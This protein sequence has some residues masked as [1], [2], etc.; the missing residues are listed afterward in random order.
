MTPREKTLGKNTR[1]KTETLP[2]RNPKKDKLSHHR[3]KFPSPRQRKEHNTRRKIEKKERKQSTWE[4]R[5]EEKKLRAK[6]VPE[7][8]PSDAREGNSQ[9]GRWKKKNCFGE[10]SS[11]WRLKNKKNGKGKALRQ[12]LL[13]TDASAKHRWPAPPRVGSPPPTTQSANV[14]CTQPVQRNDLRFQ[15]APGAPFS[16]NNFPSRTVIGWKYGSIRYEVTFCIQCPFFFRCSESLLEIDH[17]P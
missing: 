2:P 6:E 14:A 5:S 13:V 10:Q 12:S 1:S 11:L 7:M 3:Q 8:L 17:K 15:A 4:S 16:S 9:N